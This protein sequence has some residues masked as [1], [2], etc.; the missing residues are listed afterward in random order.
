MKLLA[1]DLD[2]TLF[3]PKGK[4]RCISKKNVKFLQ[5]FVDAGN[6]IVLCTSRSEAFVKRLENEIQRPFDYLACTTA[7]IV[8]ATDGVIRDIPANND[9]MADV[10]KF[11]DEKHRP[12]AYL[13]TTDKYPVL[14]KQNIPMSKL[15]LWIYHTYWKLQFCYREKYLIDNQLFDE[16][17]KSGN[18]Y[19]MM[20]FYGFGRSKKEI[21]KELNK[22][23][24]ERHPNI[25]SSWSL[26]VNELT[27][28]GCNKGEGLEY[29]CNH[30]NIDPNDVY[31][32]GDSGNDISM[33]NKYHEHSFVMSHAYPS[34]KKYAK[35]VVRRVFKLRQF[36][37]EGEK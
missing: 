29:Y 3:Y 20:V 10:L 17:L 21:S 7:K 36:V 4:K 22:I 2:G 30:Y 23:V 15:F 14:I 32:I 11:L 37:L 34:V 6:K 8:S 5:D 31:V 26:I 13:M 18:I 35:T 1:I 16:A 28:K 9:D 24:R 27:P 12:A 19:K 33:F 25:E